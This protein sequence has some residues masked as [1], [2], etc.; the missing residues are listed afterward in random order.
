MEYL[1]GSD[2]LGNQSYT[3]FQFLTDV[4]IQQTAFMY[5]WI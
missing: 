3:I 5:L 4:Q 2:I 1:G